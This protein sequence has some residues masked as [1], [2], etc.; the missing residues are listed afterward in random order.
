MRRR[1][2]NRAGLDLIKRFEGLR[3]EAYVCPAGVLTIG[4]GHTGPD[5]RPEMVCTRQKADALLHKDL[6][7]FETGV[8][9]ALKVRVTDNQYA[10]LVSLAFNI[11]L[12]AFGRSTL[13]RKVNEEDPTAADEFQ[14]WNKAKGK[15]L[16]GLTKRRAAEAALFEL[17]DER[18]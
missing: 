18:D 15:T 5:V 10:A 13:L 6:E 14:R 12:G 17:P 9:E 2:I 3:L 7:R 11:G 4:W 16:P 1:R 8:A